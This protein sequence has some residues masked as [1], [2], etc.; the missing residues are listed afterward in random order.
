[1]NKLP[2]LTSLLI[3]LTGLLTLTGN[4]QDSSGF[5]KETLA[6]TVDSVKIFGTLTLPDGND[7]CPVVLII[8]GSGPIDRDGNQPGMST[9]MYM[10][11]CDALARKGIASVSYDKRGVGESALSMEESALRFDQFIDDASGWISSIRK[12]KRFDKLVLAGHSEGS[13]IGMVAANRTP[14]DRFISIAGP[15]K[16]ID[17][18]LRKQLSTAVPDTFYYNLCC[19]YL[20][21]LKQGKTL[22]NSD[23]A[24]GSLFR[25]SIQP[26]MISWIKYD[27]A[28]EIAKLR[29]PVLIVNGETDIQVESENA[30][31][32]SKANPKATL[33]II[34]GMNHILKLSEKDRD[35]NLATYGD[36]SLPVA[37][38]LIE[39]ISQ[40]V[41]K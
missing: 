24:L 16:P 41:T 23:P 7:P 4:A 14:V 12:D 30:L 10:K 33:K 40:F 29:M 5:R 31:Q 22:I 18:I 21:T 25:S 1:M 20:D 38:E 36:P 9:N 19:R 37:T 3:I 28:I 11:L 6:V 39:A 26:Y 27:P 34:P 17:E 8:S 15:G 35:K 2:F 13:L 32:L